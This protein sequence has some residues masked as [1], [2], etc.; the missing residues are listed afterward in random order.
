MQIPSIPDYNGVL[1]SGCTLDLA[2]QIEDGRIY[3]PVLE[4]A[5]EFIPVFAVFD[6]VVKLEN[7][8]MHNWPLKHVHRHLLVDG[9]ID[10]HSFTSLN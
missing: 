2:N 7:G 6:Y 5:T 9:T 10:Y 3:G 8:K 1:F 4:Y